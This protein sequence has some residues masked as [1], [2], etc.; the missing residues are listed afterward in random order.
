LIRGRKNESGAGHEDRACDQREPAAEA[1]RA[2][3]QVKR[4]DDVAKER[5]GEK[6]SDPPVVKPHR[7]EVE[8]QQLTV[9]NVLLHVM[10]SCTKCL[11]RV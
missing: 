2:R 3:S 1:I 5:E 7:R 10:R 8:D 9:S 6:N 11:V 4:E